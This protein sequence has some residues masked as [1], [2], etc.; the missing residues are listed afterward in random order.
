ML[1]RNDCTCVPEHTFK[2]VLNSPVHQNRSRNSSQLPITRR[3]NDRMSTPLHHHAAVTR[4][5]L[6]L[7]AG[8]WM[9]LKIT[10]KHQIVRE[11]SGGGN[12]TKKSNGM[13]NTRR[14]RD[15]QEERGQSS[16]E[17]L[18]SSLSSMACVLLLECSF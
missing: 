2:R 11:L 18:T 7:W 4:N 6:Q 3:I 16:K 8:I 17:A 9:D 5:T 10:T 13:I 1:E 12:I 14:R 15:G